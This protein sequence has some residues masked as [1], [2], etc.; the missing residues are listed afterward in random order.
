VHAREK[1]QATAATGNEARSQ[2]RDPETPDLAKSKRRKS[3]QY[4]RDLKA[5]FF[6]QINQ[7]L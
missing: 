4:T 3:K 1:S 7:D 2:N 5:D 6:I